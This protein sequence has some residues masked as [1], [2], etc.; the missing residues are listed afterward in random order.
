MQ[1]LLS[2]RA[3][4]AHLFGLRERR[5]QRLRLGDHTHLRRRRKAFE[6]GLKDSMRFDETAGRLIE[7]GE[8]KR[9]EQLQGPGALLFR[10]SE[11]GFESLFGLRKIGEIALQ[12]DNAA[13]AMQ[14]GIIKP[15]PAF[16]AH[17]QS[18][19]DQRQGSLIVLRV[20]F[21]LRKSPKKARNPYAIALISIIRQRFAEVIY[22][23]RAAQ[24]GA[25]KAKIQA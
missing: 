5:E 10:D 24:H 25:T 3:W 1:P 15:I 14:V 2:A 4:G 12:K 11:G 19:V 21:K 23:L 8:R 20:R 6:R 18:F 9:R 16:L 22:A 13:Q 7:L 17:R